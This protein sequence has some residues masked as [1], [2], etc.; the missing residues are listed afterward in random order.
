MDIEEYIKKQLDFKGGGC[1]S[2]N[3]LRSISS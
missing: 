1:I 2:I 3:G